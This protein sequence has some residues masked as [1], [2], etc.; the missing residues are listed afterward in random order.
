[1]EPQKLQLEKTSRGSCNDPAI[2]G[3]TVAE[4]NAYSP[5]SNNATIRVVRID[6]VTGHV[7]EG[8]VVMSYGDYS[9]TKP[10]T[11]YGG[12]WFWIY[13]V[14]TTK[15]PELLQISTSSGRVED[16]VTMPKLYRPIL[17]ANEDG[18]WIGNSVEGSEAPD[19]LYH[20]TPGSGTATGVVAGTSLNAFWLVASGEDIWAGIGP[21]FT[22]QTIWRFDG[23]DPYPVFRVPDHGYEPTSVVGNEAEGL[24]TVVPY[25]PLGT[26]LVSGP[27]PQIVI[28]IDPDSGKETVAATLPRFVLPDD[29]GLTTAQAAYF[30]GSLFVLEPPFD[31][32]GYL[33]YTQLIRVTP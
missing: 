9:D 24:W 33:G 19:V 3:E 18:L 11:A 26:R 8:P 1:L 10:V 20:V 7:S 27:Y 21:S 14:E 25:P 5:D 28:R 17:A 23:S 22:Q 32:R 4:V 6:P 16:T 2:F 15:G 13:D 30:E 31:A 12:G 29:E